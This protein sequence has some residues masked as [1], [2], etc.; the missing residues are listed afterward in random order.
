VL[1]VK[2]YK[3]SNPAAISCWE[4]DIGQ[5]MYRLLLLF[6]FGLV[7]ITFIMETAYKIVQSWPILQSVFQLHPPEF[8]IAR[9]TMHLIYGQTLTWIA[10]YYSPISSSMF[11]FIL[12][13]TFYI[14]QVCY[15][16]GYHQLSCTFKI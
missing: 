8:E 15:C 1:S 3:S 10:L 13:A 6:F 9:N 16:Y 2:Y 4:N 7:L 12:L 5:E 11:I 14:K